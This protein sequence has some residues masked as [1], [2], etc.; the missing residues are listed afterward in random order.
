MFKLLVVQ[1]QDTMLAETRKPVKIKIPDINNL[2]GTMNVFTKAD[3]DSS[4]WND[5][6]RSFTRVSARWDWPVNYPKLQEFMIDKQIPFEKWEIGRKLSNEYYISGPIIYWGE[7]RKFVYAHKPLAK[8]VSYKI[9]KTDSTTLTVNLFE[10]FRRRGYK[11][12]GTKTFDTT[13]SVRYSSAF[14]ETTLSTI[15]YINCDRFL[16]YPQV[17]DLY[18]RTPNFDGAQILV[19]FKNINAFMQAEYKDGN[20][21]VRKVPAGEDVYLIAVGKRGDEFYYGKKAY[22]ISRKANI[23]LALEKVQYNEMKEMF[24]SLGFKN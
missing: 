18:V 1:Q 17:T 13:F 2:T 23:D 8:Y 3:S 7:K 15:N 21:R 12:F 6:Q 9:T 22:T 10:K 20:Y 19:Y 4:L 5:A 24:S 14:Y 16:N 11:R